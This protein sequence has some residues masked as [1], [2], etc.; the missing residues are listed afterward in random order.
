VTRDQHWE[1]R[2]PSGAVERLEPEAP[3]TPAQERALSCGGAELV[4]VDGRGAPDI[5]WA[6]VAVYGEPEEPLAAPGEGAGGTPLCAILIERSDSSAFRVGERFGTPSAFDAVLAAA[7]PSLG[8]EG[9]QSLGLLLMWRDGTAARC[10]LAVPRHRGQSLAG[11][12]IRA[13]DEVSA[14]SR[15]GALHALAT[16]TLEKI[17]ATSVAEARARTFRRPRLDD[18][19]AAQYSESVVLTFRFITQGVLRGRCGH[20]HKTLV[21]ATR[22]LLKD[23]LWCQAQGGG[24]HS[25]RRIFVVGGGTRRELSAVELATVEALRPAIAKEL[26]EVRESEKPQSGV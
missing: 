14:D 19:P 15:F 7:L 17:V 23:E 5:V 26:A 12:V 10:N 25:D 18:V 24:G 9:N 3:L 13:C 8:I 22:C 20:S 4:R 21:G 2:F 1:V 16:A 6:R 11:Q